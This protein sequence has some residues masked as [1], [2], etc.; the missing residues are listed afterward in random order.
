MQAQAEITDALR[1]MPEALAGPLRACL[2]GETS[3]NLALMQLCL[4]A[5][6][7]QAIEDA[8]GRFP[9]A[10]DPTPLAE[11]AR[12]WRTVPGAFDSVQRVA[13]VVDHEG[14]AASPEVQLAAFARGFDRAAELSPEAGVALYSL[15]SSELLDAATEEVVGTM[16]GW[17]LLRTDS[18][19]LEIGC[20]AGR[21]LAALAPQVGSVTGIDI[22][23]AMLGVA[24]SRC[25]AFPNVRLC[26]SSGRDLSMCGDGE[27]DFILAADSFPYIVK[28]GVE[29]ARRHFEE[30][31][32]ILRPGGFFLIVNYS[33]RGN[34]E[35]DR[36]ELSENAAAHGFTLLRVG[37]GDFKRWDGV[38]FLMR[39]NAET[40]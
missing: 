12:L 28:C 3:P 19:V 31:A 27:M 39:R 7:A 4:A 25:S 30:S 24:Q 34:L 18:H 37:M 14:E 9:A 17:G 20:G 8:L 26:L 29:L 35:D 10:H 13:G 36:R 22:S 32:R 21:F 5:P 33:Y 23:G 16:R 15:G 11:L 40:G 1:D 2:R 38:S 6:N